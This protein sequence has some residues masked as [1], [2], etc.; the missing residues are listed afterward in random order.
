M[1]YSNKSGRLRV[2]PG[3][4]QRILILQDEGSASTTTQTM[5]VRAYIRERRLTV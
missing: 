5:S 3:Q 4:T 1:I 2:W